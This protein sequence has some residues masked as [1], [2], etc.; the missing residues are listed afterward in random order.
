MTVHDPAV[1]AARRACSEAPKARAYIAAGYAIAGAREALAPI[2]ELAEEIARDFGNEDGTG[3]DLL[4]EMLH[5]LE[6]LIYTADELKGTT[7]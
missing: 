4:G 7:E 1:E 2:R 3:I 6:P 5:R